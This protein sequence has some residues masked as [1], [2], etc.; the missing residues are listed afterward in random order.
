MAISL[1]RKKIKTLRKGEVTEKY[2]AKV[3][4]ERV[5]DLNEVAMLVSRASS[6]SPGDVRGTVE[7]L[8]F[9]VAV[10]VGEGHPVDLHRLLPEE[11]DETLV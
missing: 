4:L 3:Y 1:I 9:Q 5:V 2:V 7:E 6:L 8:A 11:W 10:L